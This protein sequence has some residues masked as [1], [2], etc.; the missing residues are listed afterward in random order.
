MTHWP[1]FGLSTSVAYW[2]SAEYRSIVDGTFQG[3]DRVNSTR[4]GL[5]G[6]TASRSTG[7]TRRGHSC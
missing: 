6:Q 2:P 7:A 3:N 5:L 1:A 4:R